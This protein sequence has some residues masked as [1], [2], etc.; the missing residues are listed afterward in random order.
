MKEKTNNGGNAN[1]KRKLKWF[2]RDLLKI[3]I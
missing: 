3:L 2:Y 1:R